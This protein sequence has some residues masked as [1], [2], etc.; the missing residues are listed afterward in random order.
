MIAIK[1][2]EDTRK[3]N[4]Y[5]NEIQFPWIKMWNVAKRPMLP[6]MPPPLT[7]L[8]IWGKMPWMKNKHL[9]TTRNKAW[10]SGSR[11]ELPTLS[12]GGIIHR[13]KR[14]RKHNIPNRKWSN[15]RIS[16]VSACNRTIQCLMRFQMQNRQSARR[17]SKKNRR[18]TCRSWPLLAWT[19]KETSRRKHLKT[20][21]NLIT[22]YSTR[23]KYW[24]ISAKPV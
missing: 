7:R 9:S 2:S 19:L 8:S 11:P 5:Y 6:P 15:T 13:S 16:D 3:G 22:R 4:L 24:N 18:K 12:S 14:T 10:W 23:P 1:I 20:I 21:T 17:S